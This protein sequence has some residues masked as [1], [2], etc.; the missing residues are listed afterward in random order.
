MNLKE[1]KEI[2]KQNN[3]KIILEDTYL[4][5]MDK[6]LD[7]IGGGNKDLYE[8]KKYAPKN[9]KISGQKF[10]FE[11]DD[12]YTIS[13]E[14]WYR[15]KHSHGFHFKLFDK[16]LNKKVTS[17]YNYDTPDEFVFYVFRNRD[18]YVNFGPVEKFV[19]TTIPFE[20]KDWEKHNKPGLF[21][22]IFKRG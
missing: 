11:Y 1:A 6:E 14:T 20:I 19:D 21:K 12:R 22:R 2:L 4:D 16:K 13:G 10:K 9:I 5:D 3:Y 17:K 7:E 8:L 15:D 18:N